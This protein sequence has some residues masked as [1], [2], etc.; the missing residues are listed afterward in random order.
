MRH[1]SPWHSRLMCL[2]DNDSSLAHLQL[3]KPPPRWPRSRKSVWSIQDC[4][5]LCAE[6]SSFWFRGTAHRLLAC[7]N[8]SAHLLPWSLPLTALLQTKQACSEPGFSVLFTKISAL[9][10]VVAA[11]LCECLCVLSSFN[12]LLHTCCCFSSLLCLCSPLF[13]DCANCSC[14][15]RSCAFPLWVRRGPRFAFFLSMA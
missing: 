1:T 2:I 6:E 14:L 11:C 15:A 9:S 13:P 10:G 8:L 7:R 12:W 5:S 4:Q 3:S